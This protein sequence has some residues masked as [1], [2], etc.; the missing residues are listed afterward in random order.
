MSQQRFCVF[1]FVPSSRCKNK[2]GRPTFSDHLNRSGS[3][4]GWRSSS[5]VGPDSRMTE[6]PVLV[7]PAPFSSASGLLQQ[8]QHQSSVSVA[9][10]RDVDSQV[11]GDG[12][13]GTDVSDS[14]SE[15]SP[16]GC[17]NKKKDMNTLKKDENV[18]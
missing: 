5:P 18:E 7:D 8:Q 9:A 12:M 13:A 10:R 2:L 14:K 16:V 17:N 6:S 3:N 11:Q 1:F 4:G 15:T